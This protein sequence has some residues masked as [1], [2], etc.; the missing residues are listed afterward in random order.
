MKLKYPRYKD[1]GQQW[2]CALLHIVYHHIPIAK[3]EIPVNPESE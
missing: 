2:I 1:G 3:K